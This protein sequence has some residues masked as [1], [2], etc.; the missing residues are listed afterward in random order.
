MMSTLEEHQ[1]VLVRASYSFAYPDLAMTEAPRRRRAAASGAE[2]MRK[3]EA[4]WCDA[5][6]SLYGL[7]RTRRCHAFYVVY[8]GRTILFCAPGVGGAAGGFAVATNGDA[9][10]RRALH[11]ASVDFTSADEEAAAID[12]AKVARAKPWRAEDE[13]ETETEENE[14]LDRLE[15]ETPVAPPAPPTSTPRSPRWTNRAR[16]DVAPR[17]LSCV[18]APS[19]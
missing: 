15:G 7:L 2:W 14:L 10:L 5:L 3:R 11:D 1:R 6:V 18:E 4:M 16:L 13:K 9:A 17:I 19:R 8:G 12:R